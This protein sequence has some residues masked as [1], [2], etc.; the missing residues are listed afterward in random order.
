[1]QRYESL[2][3]ILYQSKNA[4]SLSKLLQKDCNYDVT[5]SIIRYFYHMRIIISVLIFLVTAQAY[6]QRII[7]LPKTEDGHQWERAEREFYSEDWQNTVITNVAQP[8]LHAYIPENPTGMSV[9]IA[10]GGGM[11]A[12]S[13]ESEGR[14]VARWLSNKGISAFVLKYRLVP[15]GEDGVKDLTKDGMQVLLKARKMLPHAIQDAMNAIK[16]LRSNSQDLNIDS[17]KIG[18]IGFSAGGAV[19]METRYKCEG[20]S[21]PNFIGPIYAWMN[22]VDAQEITADFGPIFI[23]CS[24]DDPLQLAPASIDIYKQWTEAGLQA[25]L[26]MYAKG[27]HGYGMKKQELPS[28]KWIEQFYE[29][30]VGIN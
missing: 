3:H 21:C 4:D 1:V 14:D 8:E 12:H 16:Y 26:H 10:P 20:D 22:I 24:T 25:E 6:S 15:T 19:T 2:D 17:D 5:Q 11:Y 13:I 9:I 7:K 29:W 28:D 23:A 27:G 18:L 30:M